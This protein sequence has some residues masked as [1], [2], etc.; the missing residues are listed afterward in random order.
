MSERP[1]REVIDLL[2]LFDRPT[3]AQLAPFILP[4]HGRLQRLSAPIELFRVIGGPEAKTARQRH[5]W[6]PSVLGAL[7]VRQ[8]IATPAVNRARR[9]SRRECIS[10]ANGCPA[11]RQL[12]ATLFRLAACR[13]SAVR[14]ASSTPERR[15]SN[16]VSRFVSHPVASATALFW[17]CTRRVASHHLK[18]CDTCDGATAGPG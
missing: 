18:R 16:V 17:S 4:S 7:D 3:V 5:R 13:S 11:G 10:V 15:A 6:P 14:V 1:S 9:S 8:L 2:P 12:E